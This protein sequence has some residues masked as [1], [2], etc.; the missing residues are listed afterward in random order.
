MSAEPPAPRGT[1]AQAQTPKLLDR[2]RT[3]CRVRHDSLRTEEAYAAWMVRFIRFHRLHHPL[4]M[5]AAE[6]NAFLTHLAVEG[7]LSAS[8]QNQA[9]SALLF[10][11]Q[12]VLE[13]DPGR[14]EGVVRAKRPQR[15]PVVLTREEVRR[16][17]G[18]MEGS[19][20]LIALLLYGAG[21]RLIECLR[22]RVQDLDWER[23]EVLVRHGKGGKDRRT[24]LPA[25]ARAD[26]AAHLERVH[27]L[28]RRDVGRGGG[29]VELPFATDRK[30]P[31]AA[32]DWRWQYVFP[33]ATI[34]TDPRSRERR[35]HHAHPGAV[36]RAIGEAG[37][38][39]GL[40][41]RATA[42]SLRHSFATHLIEDG[43][44]IRTVQEL[45]GHADVSTTMIYTHVLS[46]GGKGV[47]SPL[48][49]LGS[50]GAG[51]GVRGALYPGRRARMKRERSACK[52]R[53]CA[54]AGDAAHSG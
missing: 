51:G 39:A 13:V 19:Y 15:L 46:K 5:G 40:S 12:K 23:G 25:A 14:I 10:L 36:T 26:L 32:T 8:T 24:M 43:Y 6:V 1:A 44:D 48:D 47:R 33:S 49:G 21:L 20:R 42:H 30:D 41:K 52:G 11:Y 16:T 53:N 54:D 17:L 4:E 37:T 27:A 2:R 22:L 45:L 3:A 7:H 9:F 29:R 31:S 28:H 34:G 38:R 18:Q 50:A 35:R